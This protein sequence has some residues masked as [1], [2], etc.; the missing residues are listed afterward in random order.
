MKQRI[1]ALFVLTLLAAACGGS[2]ESASSSEAATES[3]SESGDRTTTTEVAT[4]SASEPAATTTTTEAPTE[5]TIEHRG[6]TTVVPAQ[7]ER[8][9]V[10]NAGTMLPI[11]LELG[12]ETIVGAPI[13]DGPITATRLLDDADLVDVAP[14]GFPQANPELVAAETPDLIMMFDDGAGNL[15]DSYEIFAQVAPTVAVEL[16]LNDWRGTGERVAA[17]LGLEAEMAAGLAGYDARVAALR[18]TIGDPSSVEVT[19]VRALGANIRLHTPF[20]HAGQVFADVGFAWAP[21]VPTDDPTTRLVQISLEE[22]N[23]AD[24]DHV[25]VFGAGQAVDGSD[26]DATVQAILDHPLYPTLRVAESGNLH[27]V[28]PLG[29][30]QGGLP[31]AL[32]ILSDL[33][34]VFP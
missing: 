2:D 9:V 23:Q 7:P 30:Q 22:L 16:D 4:E 34:G 25:F 15:P 12:V 20:H 19:V 11:L 26:V 27:V 32:L 17:V 3:A 33:E 31:G 6:G 10:L 28:D 18:E 21:A 14:V 5:R 1:G 8:I 13:P 24:A 29:W